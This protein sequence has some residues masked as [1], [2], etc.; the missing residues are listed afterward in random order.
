[1]RA[2][3]LTRFAWPLSAA[4]LFDTTAKAMEIRQY[5]KMVDRDQADY[6]QVLVDGAQKVLNNEGRSDFARKMDQL[7]TEIPAGDK[8]SLGMQ[9]FENNLALAR[10]TDA[11]NVI[12]DP[13]AQRLEVEDVMAATLEKKNGIELPDSFFTVGSNFKPK[14]PTK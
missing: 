9:E 8:I 4:M 1:M 3:R 7:F 13:N 10:V 2:S 14:F 11:K 5:D 6:I 12:K